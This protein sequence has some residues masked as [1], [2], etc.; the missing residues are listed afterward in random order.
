MCIRREALLGPV[1]VEEGELGVAAVAVGQPEV[2]SPA[3][4]LVGRAVEVGDG[5]FAPLWAY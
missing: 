2:D 1:E 3:E 4:A 5:A